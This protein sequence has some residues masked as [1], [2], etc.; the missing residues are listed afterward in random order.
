[1]VIQTCNDNGDNGLLHGLKPKPEWPEAVKKD[2]ANFV[3]KGG[4]VYIF[5]AAEN[6]FR[7]LERI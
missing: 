4:G 2:F 5:H 7:G 6:A 1:V 3:R